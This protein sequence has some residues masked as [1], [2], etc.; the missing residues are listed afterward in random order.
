M[1]TPRQ[2]VNQTIT[3][4]SPPRPTLFFRTNPERSD[5]VQVPFISPTNFVNVERTLDEW[6]CLWGNTIG[7]GT[8]YILKHPLDQWDD[9]E[10]YTFPNPRSPSRF[11]AIEDAVQRYPHK[12][13]VA[14]LG[15][16]GFSVLTALRG[17]ENVLT[18]LY[19]NNDKLYRLAKLVFEF[20]TEAIEEISRCRADG[21]WFFD[22]WGMEHSLFIRP[23]LWRSFFKPLYR[24]QFDRVHEL[25]M[26]TFF[27]SCGYV[28]PIIPDL[29]E[30]GVD[31][32]NLEQ[33]DLFSDGSHTGYERIAHEFGQQVSFTIN[34]DS[35]RTLTSGT[36]AQIEQEVRHIFR[37]FSKLNGGFI[38]FADAG[39]D[40][41]IHPPEN[42]KLIED[43]CVSLTFQ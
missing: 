16:T 27:H 31:V 37:T 14:S 15:L 33:M 35:Q 29:I 5:I 10:C 18:D 26:R 4:R 22:D 8:G 21:V 11:E 36:P 34:V 7:T 2:I 12:F 39:K 24:A 17:F 32:L 13:V 38:V 40:H 9:F 3:R 28:W 1:Q 41:N 6:G 43:M 23:D 20:E 25:G 19:L 42:L 30:I